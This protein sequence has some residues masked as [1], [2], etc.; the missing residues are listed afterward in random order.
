M[1]WRVYKNIVREGD[2]ERE[3][4]REGTCWTERKPEGRPIPNFLPIPISIFFFQLCYRELGPFA[5]PHFDPTW[6]KNLAL[7]T[8]VN[9]AHPLP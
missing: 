1:W 7:K 6:S 4:E 5:E 3:G 2:R 9:Y 8:L